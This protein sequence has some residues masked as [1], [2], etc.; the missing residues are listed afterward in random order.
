MGR[1]LFAR[2]D[3]SAGGI[4]INTKPHIACLS[5]QNLPFFC[6]SC[7]S[8]APVGKELKRCTKCKVLYYCSS[9]CQ[10]NDWPI[11][12]HECA[13]LRKWSKN[14]PSQDHAIPNDAIRSLGHEGE[15]SQWTKEIDR[16]QSNRTKL[17]VSQTE[18]HT[19]LAHAIVQYLGANSPADL[20]EYGISSVADLVDVISRFISNTFAIATSSLTPLGASVSPP[21][22][23]TNHSCDPNAVIVYPRVSATPEKDE[24]VMQLVAVRPIKAGE[25]VLTSY[26]DT[27]LT[28]K[29]RQETLLETYNFVCQCTLCDKTEWVDP[30]EALRCPQGCDGLCPIPAEDSMLIQCS[31][32]ASLVPDVPGSSILRPRRFRRIRQSQLSPINR[33]YPKLFDS[34]PKLIPLLDAAGFSPAAHPLLALTRLHQSILINTF[35]MLK[36]HRIFWMRLFVLRLGMSQ[37]SVRFLWKD[38]LFELLLL[39]EQ[40]KI[41]SMDEPRVVPSGPARLK[42][43]YD[44]LVRA[45]K[46]LLVGFGKANEGGEVGREMRKLVVSLEKEIGVWK[47]GVRNVLQDDRESSKS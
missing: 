11:H 22:A 43:A 16:L 9:T 4:I 26:I 27:T 38:I 34:Y 32:C 14:A 6:G 30:R 5:T 46:E 8:Q 47:Y 28:R 17:P 25:Q 7:F 1:G 18:M 20:S 44:V 21:I 36:L 40:G 23:L 3:I 19:H 35:Q 42:L 29:S 12:K 15:D 13:A 2:K 41:L 10:G 33:H 37:G 31:K 24:P 45:R 39:H